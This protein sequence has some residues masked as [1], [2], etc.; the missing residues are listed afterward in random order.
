MPRELVIRRL[1][2]LGQPATLFG[3]DDG[4]RYLRLRRAQKELKV[5]DEMLG[6]EG[7]NAMHAAQRQEKADKGKKAAEGG[8]AAG[9]KAKA[10]GKERGGGDKVRAAASAAAGDVGWGRRRR[11]AAPPSAGCS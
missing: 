2:G 4:A 7:Q 10:G 9:A 11:A 3:E 8:G 1:R 6:A 5:A